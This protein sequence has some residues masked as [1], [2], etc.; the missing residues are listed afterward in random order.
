ML[1]TPIH[2]RNV[3]KAFKALSYETRL[4]IINLLLDRECC[5]CEV[6]Q[7]MRISQTRASRGLTALQD[8]GL[9]KARRDGLW[10]LYSID[11]EGIEESYKGLPQL[12]RSALEGSQIAAL[13]RERLKTA[14]RE[15]PC[16]ERTKT[17]GR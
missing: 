9:L 10:V 7:A 1:I 17:L 3:L 6:M 5:V 14:V 11:Q 13:D 16:I 4:R 2:M 12:I 15:S 8:A